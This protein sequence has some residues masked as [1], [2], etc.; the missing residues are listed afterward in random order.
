HQTDHRPD[1]HAPERSQDR[2]PEKQEEGARPPDQNRTQPMVFIASRARFER[3]HHVPE[4]ASEQQ[5]IQDA[6]KHWRIGSGGTGRAAGAGRRIIPAAGH[7]TGKSSSPEI[8]SEL[9]TRSSLA[10]TRST[11]MTWLMTM[12]S[13]SL[14]KRIVRRPER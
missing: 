1:I 11:C 3:F 5:Q 7:V 8:C 2:A 13:D 6:G 12:G 10:T 14:G 9:A 4:A